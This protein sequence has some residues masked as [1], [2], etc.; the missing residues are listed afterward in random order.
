MST[1]VREVSQ[2][3]RDV[4]DGVCVAGGDRWG[5]AYQRRY[6]SPVEVRLAGVRVPPPG[7]ERGG[8]DIHVLWACLNGG[9]TSVMPIRKKV[10]IVTGA[11]EVSRIGV[12]GEMNIVSTILDK[13]EGPSARMPTVVAGG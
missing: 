8:R 13:H 1:M 4:G 9:A 2:W 3:S 7:G 10:S 11:P 12:G 5:R 6:S